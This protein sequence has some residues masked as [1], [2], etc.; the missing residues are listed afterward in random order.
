MFIQSIKAGV[1]GIGCLLAS[2][3]HA[4]GSTVNENLELRSIPSGAVRFY[5]GPKYTWAEYCP[6]NTC[7]VIR[8]SASVSNKQ[9]SL[10]VGAY[11]YYFSKY[12][13]LTDWQQ[14]LSVGKRVEESLL[15]LRGEG[16]SSASGRELAKCEIL[17]WNKNY[18][19]QVIFVRF[20]EQGRESQ[21]LKLEDVLQ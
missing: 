8:T 16:C 15:F 21:R 11:F 9:F 18:T 3:G 6:D 7:E 4:T 12:S 19:I 1:F 17:R 13:Y 14:V 20:D 10:L 5:S 2:S